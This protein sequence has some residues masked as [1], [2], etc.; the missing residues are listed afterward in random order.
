MSADLFAEYFRAID[1]PD[2]QFYQAD[3]DVIEFNR[4]FLYTETNVMI[5]ELAVENSIQEINNAIRELNLGRSGGPDKLL[6]ELIIH[7]RNVLLPH[8]CKLFNTLPN[9]GYFPSMWAEGY[10]VPIHKKGNVNNV[11]NYRGIVLLLSILDKLFTRILT[12]RLT[13][14]A[15]TYYVYID[16]QTA[17]SAGMGNA[18][19]IFVL[20]GIIT[21]L[22][23]Q[24][25][26]AILCFRRFK[27]KAFDFIN[28]D[29]I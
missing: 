7:E 15:E 18:D 5:A 26:K 4:R 29:I 11:D 19:N 21:H 23:N 2:N 8:L 24:G 28:R 16:A 14:W 20:H 27:K 1:I 10:I 6:N 13:E 9:K 3:E 25:K 17:F 12:T 22:I